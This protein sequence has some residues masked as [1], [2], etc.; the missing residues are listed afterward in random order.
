MVLRGVMLL[1][2]VIRAVV[3]GMLGA[4]LCHAGRVVAYF[5]AVASSFG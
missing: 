3:Y 5:H 1:V 2:G 4:A